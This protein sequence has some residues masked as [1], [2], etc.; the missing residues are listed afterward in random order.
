VLDDGEI[1]QHGTHQ[2]LIEQEGLYKALYERQ[3]QSEE[4]E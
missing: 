3:L 4:S 1:V 2:E